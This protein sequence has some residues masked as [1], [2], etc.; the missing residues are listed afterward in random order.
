M[1]NF[2]TLRSGLNHA[3]AYQVSGRPW[4]TGSCVAPISGTLGATVKPNDQPVTF[5]YVTRW[6][7]I[8]VSSSVAIGAMGGPELRVAFSREGLNDNKATS[9]SMGGRYFTMRPGDTEV[10]E[11]KV[12]ELH[13]M[14]SHDSTVTFNVI[15]GLTSIANTALVFNTTGSSWSGSAG[16]G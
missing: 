15:A 13:F 12:S 3:P 4:V 5:P 1:G 16:V 8:Q 7:K 9:G 10:M 14:S 6:V 2:N 11:L